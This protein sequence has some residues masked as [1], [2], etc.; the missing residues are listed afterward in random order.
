MPDFGLLLGVGSG[1]SPLSVPNLSFLYYA[2]TGTYKESTL[3]TPATADG[4]TVLGVVDQSGNGRTATQATA[5]NKMILST[6][7]NAKML[8]SPTISALNLSGWGSGYLSLPAAVSYDVRNITYYAVIEYGVLRNQ[9]VMFGDPGL[10]L[11][12]DAGN[13][14]TLGYNNTRSTIVNSSRRSVYWFA[15]S[16]AGVTVGI[17]DTSAVLAAVAT[18][19][20][21][22][23]QVFGYSANNGV[24]S[25][26]WMASMLYAGP[27][28]A[29]QHS[30]MLAFLYAKYSIT[31]TETSRLLCAGDSITAG[32][33]A[34]GNRG[35]ARQIEA[36]ISVNCR[37]CN[38]GL[39]GV[40]T[41]TLNGTLSA[42]CNVFFSGSFPCVATYAAGTNDINTG[43]AAA[44]V[45]T[46]I[47]S[48]C[49]TLKTKGYTVAV[50]SIL[51]R[52]SIAGANE[53]N[54]QA[55]NTWL[56]ANYATF[57]DIYVDVAA[58]SRLNNSSNTTYYNADATH[59]TVAGYG[60][61][62]SL[63]QAA[64]G[65]SIPA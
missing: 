65:A 29:G 31:R 45:E 18:S 41:T 32:Y 48:G 20:Q 39:P 27:L 16:G 58:D 49:Q 12:F 61:Y 5:G 13:N 56:A 2:D 37:V 54:R 33:L 10:H 34:T 30:A 62:A 6:A 60:V 59:L 4:D 51:P 7:G 35:W 17:N 46:N 23:G 63:V 14:F 21:T 24:P 25:A 43:V 57:A 36:L 38:I 26:A 42:D 53:T 47:Q 8:T 28:T 1:F 55:V 11:L 64:I 19:A 9:P 44:T 15:S 52:G 3:V 22:A 40:T 50:M